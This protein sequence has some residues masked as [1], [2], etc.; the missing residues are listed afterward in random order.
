LRSHAAG[1]WDNPVDIF[2]VIKEMSSSRLDYMPRPHVSLGAKAY[3]PIT[4]PLRRYTDFINLGQMASFLKE[5]TIR[6]SHDDLQRMLPYLSA[7]IEAV[8]KIQRYRTRYWKLLYFK[9]RYKGTDWTGI[10]VSDDG[11]HVTVS[12]PREQILLKGPKNLFGDKLYLGQRFRL[13]L[14]HIDPL[15]NEIKI[16]NAWEE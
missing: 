16:T 7:R 8:G 10:V 13:R 14:G 5:G 15:N 12:L 1:I 11:P 3:S 4:S 9:K 6:W 2:Q